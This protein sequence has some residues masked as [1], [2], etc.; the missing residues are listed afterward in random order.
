MMYLCQECG[1][2][3][4]VKKPKEPGWYM[5]HCEKCGAELGP[6]RDA[7]DKGVA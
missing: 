6:F 3:S 5:L 2:R 4:M 7:E 1:E